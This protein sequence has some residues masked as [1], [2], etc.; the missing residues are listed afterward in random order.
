MLVGEVFDDC[1]DGDPCPYPDCA[2]VL[3]LAAD[4]EELKLI[5]SSDDSHGRYATE[6]EI[7]AVLA[8]RDLIAQASPTPPSM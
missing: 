6:P 4:G 8:A 7:E 1:R 5:C 2:G 3:R